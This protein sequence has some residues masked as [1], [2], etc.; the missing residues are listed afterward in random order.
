MVT[1]AGEPVVVQQEDA[2]INVNMLDFPCQLLV[3]VRIQKSVGMYIVTHCV[4]G[5][6]FRNLL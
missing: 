1:W 5:S 2:Q 6:V 3:W 4:S